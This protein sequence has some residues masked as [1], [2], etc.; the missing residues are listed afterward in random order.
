MDLLTYCEEAINFPVNKN[1]IT[2]TINTDDIYEWL[3]PGNI[4]G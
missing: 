1:L 4:R 3:R 2:A